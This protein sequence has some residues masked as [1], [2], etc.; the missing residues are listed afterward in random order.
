MMKLFPELRRPWS[1]GLVSALGIQDYRDPFE[2]RFGLFGG[3]DDSGGGSDNV[4]RSN[5]NEMAARER[6]AARAGTVTDSRG[7]AVT[8]VNRDGSRSVVTTGSQ[9]QQ[10]AAREAF[11]ATDPRASDTRSNYAQD[12]YDQVAARETAA[13]NR[14]AEAGRLASTSLANVGDVTQPTYGPFAADQPQLNFVAPQ[15]SRPEVNLSATSRPDIPA[16]A[17]NMSNQILSRRVGSPAALGIDS[18]IAMT[19]LQDR[20]LQGDV[21]AQDMLNQAATRGDITRDQADY[22]FGF[23]QQAPASAVGQTLAE[24]ATAANVLQ[25]PPQ[26]SQIQRV[27]S[28][29]IFGPSVN[30]VTAALDYPGVAR[31]TLATGVIP[32][33]QSQVLLSDLTADPSGTARFG[34]NY[35]PDLASAPASDFLVGQQSSVGRP[36]LV[37]TAA[38]GSPITTDEFQSV[39]VD[40]RGMNVPRPQMSVI[41]TAAADPMTQL[42]QQQAIFGLGDNAPQSATSA[43]VQ[44]VAARQLSPLEQSIQAAVDASTR[45]FTPVSSPELMGEQAAAG[46]PAESFYTDAYRE[47]Y[48][49]VEG[50]IPGT[51]FA[52]LSNAIQGYSPLGAISR[53][54][55]G[56]GPLDLPSASE[57]AAFNSG[58]LLS[59][60]GTMNEQTGAISGAKAGRG[61][62]NMNRFGMV[63]YSGMPDPSYDG[64]YANLV[65][66]PADTG[67]DGDQPMQQATADPCPEGYQ[68]V[69]GVCQPV[70]DVTADDPAAPGSNFVIN[71]TTGLPTLFQPTTQATQVGQIQ[72]FVLQP[73]APQ[74]IAAPQGI[75]ALSPTGAAL[76]R[77]V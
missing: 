76:G 13:L 57:Q 62:L 56:A 37:G 16:N 53:K 15:I 42:S 12:Q 23:T 10:V 36:G 43:A 74:Q 47:L 45:Q 71:P 1:D 67:G 61:E 21:E 40:G 69:D 26:L 73:N 22:A 41:N 50:N 48:P 59:M 8:S 29:K 58:Q 11:N 35:L 27:R 39:Y 66:P 18:N 63:T 51:G 3:P 72:P 30:S 5:P 68:M 24:N 49:D 44:Q 9:A 25:G 28:D 34:A 33:D 32:E 17:Q 14:A 54:L 4:D 77:Q 38:D 6:A 60:G 64:P 46:T 20:A 70:D 55:T 65:N 7:N 31:D 52:A 75:Q 2:I 19:A